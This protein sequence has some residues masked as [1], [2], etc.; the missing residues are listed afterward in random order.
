MNSRLAFALLAA[1]AALL[2]GANARADTGKLLLTGG[3]STVEG[4]AG[5]GLTP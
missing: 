2:G 1:W 5:G 4:T 3:V